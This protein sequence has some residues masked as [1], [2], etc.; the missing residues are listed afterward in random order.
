MKANI[1]KLSMRPI[2]PYSMV[3]FFPYRVPINPL[4]IAKI[5][6]KSAKNNIV[7]EPCF[8]GAFRYMT[9]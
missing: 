4:G 9:V 8:T 1:K 2:I 7:N 5:R 3:F 6:K